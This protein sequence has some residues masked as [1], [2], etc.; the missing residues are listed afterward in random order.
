MRIF[1]AGFQHETN[2]FSRS[3]ADWNAF[4]LGDN[5]PAFVRGDELISKFEGR[6]IPIQGFIERA[7]ENGWNI[8]PSCW[9]GATPSGPITRDAFEHIADMIVD[10]LRS[11]NASGIVDAIYLDLHGAAVAEHEDDPEGEILSRL[12][13]VIGPAVPIVASLDLHANV[14]QRMLQLADAMVAYRTYPHVDMS[15]TG[16]RAAVLLERRLRCGRREQLCMRR[17]PFLLSLNA[18]CTM[19]EP[20]SSI[21]SLLSDTDMTSKTLTSFAMGFAGADVPEAGPLLW[22]YGDEA[23]K[24]VD[25]V[26]EEIVRRRP[27]WRVA[28]LNTEDS[29]DEALRLAITSDE[30][31][32]IADTQDNSGGGGSGKSTGILHALLNAGAGRTLPGRVAVGLI[33]DP[34]AAMAAHHAGLGAT[35]ELE[36]GA[37]VPCFDGTD[38]EPPV[39]GPFNV[40]AI[41]SG[42]A[43]VKGPMYTGWSLDLGLCA[44]LEKDGILI[45]ICSSNTQPLDRE[46][47]RF[48]GITPE[49]MKIISLKSSV[50]FRGDFSSISQTVIVAKSPGPMAVD[51][52]DLPWKKISSGLSTRP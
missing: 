42:C 11:A 50:N 14:S 7:R 22:A 32:I 29:V 30:P 2:T 25:Q 45:G 4:T 38:S 23:N 33:Y 43:V 1:V 5:F 47:I 46:L 10:D 15:E 37:S 40:R 31:V 18:Q 39:K 41:S 19:L 36:V 13:S 26:Y 3:K 24:V 48:V 28:T 34:A 49:D 17:I 16:R 51:P 27:E 20:A 12:R 9:A 35:I 52:E 8:V 6:N 21:Y 44:C